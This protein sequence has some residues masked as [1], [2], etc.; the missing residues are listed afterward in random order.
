MHACSMG[1]TKF[2]ARLT[3][4]GYACA[5]TR[6]V[7]VLDSTAAAARRVDQH[8][9]GVFPLKSTSHKVGAFQ[10]V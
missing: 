5:A 4:T 2:R 3:A 1:A 10:F 9:L 7:V 8:A 6:Y